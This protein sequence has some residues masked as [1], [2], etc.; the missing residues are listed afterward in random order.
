MS[1]QSYRLAA[2]VGV[3]ILPATSHPA[4]AA[5]AAISHAAVVERAN[6]AATIEPQASRF[7]QAVQLQAFSEGAIYHVMTAPG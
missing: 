3:V 7:V 6:R 1:K 2:L 4:L 5:A